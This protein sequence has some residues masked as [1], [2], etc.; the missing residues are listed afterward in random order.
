MLNY[1]L[2]EKIFFIKL[3]KPKPKISN[4][5]NREFT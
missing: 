5:M 2:E 3:V 1:D 4:F